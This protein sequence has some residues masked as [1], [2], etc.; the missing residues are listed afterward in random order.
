MYETFEID[1]FGI[2]FDMWCLQKLTSA[3]SQKIAEEV[4]AV[5]SSG[6]GFVEHWIYFR[7]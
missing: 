6:C 1:F 2:R 3:F 7:L 4:F 5:F